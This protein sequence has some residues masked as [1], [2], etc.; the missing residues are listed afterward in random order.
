M[1]LEYLR[2][3]KKIIENV[4]LKLLWRTEKCQNIWR[5]WILTTS[6]LFSTFTRSLIEYESNSINVTWN[7]KTKCSKLKTQYVMKFVKP[8]DSISCNRLS[9]KC[10]IKEKN[11]LRAVKFLLT[12][13]RK[14]KIYYLYH[15]NMILVIVS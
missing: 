9:V 8:F 4:M 13:Y 5:F 14:W 6:F 7:R 10:L 12:T 11:I 2:Y 3:L 1:Y 15:Q